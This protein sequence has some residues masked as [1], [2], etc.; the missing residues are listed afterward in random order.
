MNRILF[1]IVIAFLLAGM[2]GCAGKQIEKTAPQL[3]EEGEQYFEK[4]DYR[5][6]AESYKRLKDWYPYSPHA[7]LALL[8]VAD[9]HYHMDQYEEAIYHYEQY[10]QLY[11]ND[12]EI[13]YVVY[14]IGRSHFDRIRT[15]D[16]T[17]VP[18]QKALETFERLKARFPASEYAEKVDPRI[19]KCLENI[20]GHDVYIGRFY[21]RSG[22]YAAAVNRFERVVNRY[23]DHLTVYGEASE[24]LAMA[25]KKLEEQ[26][27]VPDLPAE[28]T[29]RSGPDAPAP[30]TSAEDTPDTVPAP[31]PAPAP[32]PGP[33][34]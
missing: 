4:G 6:A 13:P 27:E 12:P 24:Y 26:E 30:D 20:A 19:E 10:E 11:P 14:Q 18:A 34:L 32:T 3:A 9:S 7:K 25:R 2:A 8:R 33:G 28:A 22:H 1:A 23:P 29:Q 5:R 15:I 16:R 17:Q 31:S 21:F